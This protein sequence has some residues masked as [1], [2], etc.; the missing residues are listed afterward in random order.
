MKTFKYVLF[1][2]L[3]LIVGFS[4]YVAVQP[5]SYDVK[6]T[7]LIKAPVAMVFH[8]INDF[9]NWE[10]WGPWKAED[11]DMT[12]T[13]PEKT[14]GIGGNYSWEGTEGPGY[15]ETVAVTPNKSIDQKISFAGMEPNDVYWIFNEVENGTE[16]TWGMKHDKMNFMFKAFAV[17]QGGMEK[18]LGIMFN[19]GLNKL[20]NIVTEEFK[21]IPKV[22]YRLDDVV[23]VAIPAQKFIGYK[24]NTTTDLS[25]EE[26]TNLFTEFMPKAGA[27]AMRK[28]TSEDFIPGTYY[29]KWDEETKEAEFYIGLL[30]KK[31][32]APA[33]GMTS[34][35]VPEG[36]AVK[37][38]KYGNYGSGDYEAHTAIGKYMQDNKLEMNGTSVWELYVN[39]PTTVKPEDIQTDIY[40]PIK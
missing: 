35:N 5:N 18:N 13:Y 15:M 32:L 20:D 26:M 6:R 11:P 40:Y 34:F 24:Q 27:Y 10:N 2:L 8:Q 36:N 4:V 39:D 25:P 16:V 31:E 12:I 1:L 30:L 19:K 7:K 23:E 28:L 22:D 21:K 14:A 38:A 29:T 17:A 9:K 33:Q 3:I 37:I